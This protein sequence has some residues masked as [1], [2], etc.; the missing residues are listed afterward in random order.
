MRQGYL[1]VCALLDASQSMRERREA[2][3]GALREFVNA[4]REETESGRRGATRIDV[5][6]FSDRLERVVRDADP[7]SLDF[8]R[9][10]A[11]Y[12]PQGRT[13]L[14][15]AF[16]DAVDAL[17]ED[18]SNKSY[19]EQPSEV[20][21][22]FATDGRDNASVSHSL[23][24]LWSRYDLQHNVYSWRFDFLHARPEA[25][26][27]KC[28]DDETNAFEEL[29][30]A[31]S[32][33][34]VEAPE[35][36]DATPAQTVDAD[37][38]ATPTQSV[39]ADAPS[40]PA[41]RVETDDDAQREYEPPAPTDDAFSSTVANDVADNFSEHVEAPE[42]PDA[43]LAQEA[44]WEPAPPAIVVDA[45]LPSPTDDHNV[46]S[47]TPFPQEDKATL[48]ATPTRNETSTPDEEPARDEAPEFDETST[49][50]ETPILPPA[51]DEIAPPAANANAQLPLS[52]PQDALDEETLGEQVGAALSAN[53]P[54]NVAS[55]NADDEEDAEPLGDGRALLSDESTHREPREV[56]LHPVDAPKPYLEAPEDVPLGEVSLNVDDD[57]SD[58]DDETSSLSDDVE[59][60]LGEILPP[61]SEIVA[62]ISLYARTDNETEAEN[63]ELDDSDEQGVDDETEAEN[64]ELDEADEQDDDA[65]ESENEELD[66]ANEQDDDDI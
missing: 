62:P 1:H 25:L 61:P 44:P 5:F 64:E 60:S 18:F 6:F 55:Q 22:L 35:L 56:A 41:Q 54:D 7:A 2:V 66:E 23:N 4:R 65:S 63:E 13:A 12:R 26:R 31:W 17:G 30:R 27:E 59:D 33:T 36:P 42:L 21:F 15:D 14:C 29:R 3:L 49:P 58:D 47:E 28:P 39:I 46:L 34:S 24:D 9:L 32:Q 20:W 40:A 37:P 57:A 11:L 51:F 38:V 50:E 52:A 10:D 8:E 45:P 16:C 43:P 48:A 19:E 53:A